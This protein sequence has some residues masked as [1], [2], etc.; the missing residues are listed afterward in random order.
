MPRPGVGGTKAQLLEWG[1]AESGP[2]L[3]PAEGAIADVRVAPVSPS[4]PFHR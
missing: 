4:R 1:R 2:L 3:P